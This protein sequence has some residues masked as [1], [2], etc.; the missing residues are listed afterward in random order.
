MC[1]ICSRVRAEQ[2][3]ARATAGPRGGAGL[4]ATRA[5]R[6]A[7]NDVPI[8]HYVLTHYNAIK[9]VEAALKKTGKVDREALV[10]G[11]QGLSIDSPTG[12]MAIGKADHHV[13]MNMYL[14]RTEGAG[15]TVVQALG[16]L[17]PQAGCAKK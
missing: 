3:P 7:G 1:A 2:L 15:L 10:N 5:L 4:E 17:A 14:A 12:P 9:S 13:T 8:S 6:S 16:A 11:L